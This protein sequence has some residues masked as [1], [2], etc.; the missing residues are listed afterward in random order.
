[1]AKKVGNALIAPGLSGTDLLPAANMDVSGERNARSLAAMNTP[2]AIAERAAAATSAAPARSDG[3]TTQPG[4][5]RDTLEARTR[6]GRSPA[7]VQRIQEEFQQV[8]R[9]EDSAPRSNP[10]TAF[11]RDQTAARE[12]MLAE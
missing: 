11:F 6:G 10:V 3:G 9:A 2:E 7:E 12:D 1:A 4:T 5:L 8:Q